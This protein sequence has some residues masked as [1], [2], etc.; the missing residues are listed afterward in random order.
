MFIVFSFDVFSP[1]ASASEMAIGFLMHNI[2]TI[3]LIAFVWLA[4]RVELVGAIVVGLLALFF[5][6]QFVMS[7]GKGSWPIEELAAAIAITSSMMLASILFFLNW[8]RKRA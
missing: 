3:I 1:D 2:P 8:K 4:W 6:G 5:I 7:S